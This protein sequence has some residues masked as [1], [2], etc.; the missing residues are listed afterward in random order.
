MFNKLVDD[1]I[2]GGVVSNLERF[3]YY[4]YSS[5]RSELLKELTFHPIY[6]I[7]YQ[8]TKEMLES[9][10]KLSCILG[11]EEEFKEIIK[12]GIKLEELIEVS[13]SRFVEREFLVFFSSVV[14]GGDIDGVGAYSTL[15]LLD[16]TIGCIFKD[17]EDKLREL[18][19]NMKEILD[20]TV[21]E[22]KYL[23]DNPIYT[24]V[25]TGKNTNIS[26]LV[27]CK[28]DSIEVG[29]EEYEKLYD[30]S[31]LL[32]TSFSNT[33][34]QNYDYISSSIPVYT[35]DSNYTFSIQILEP[36]RSI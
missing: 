5:N 31:D 25:C 12:N 35:D 21:Y 14:E 13:S 17:N 29:S 2:M 27:I 33:N 28:K 30:K 11:I 32:Y 26:P 20:G 34:R 22:V 4:F 3:D 6:A 7:N 36:F 1:T 24:G 10:I 23:T 15:V 18:N 16:L 9:Y 19:E 8:Y